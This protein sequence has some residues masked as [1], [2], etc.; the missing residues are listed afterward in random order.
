MGRSQSLD[1]LHR[2]EIER[3]LEERGEVTVAELADILATSADTIYPVLRSLRKEG[4]VLPHP[5]GTR[6]SVVTWRW[7]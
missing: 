6:R 3:I 7:N 5:P 1:D 4:K 2:G